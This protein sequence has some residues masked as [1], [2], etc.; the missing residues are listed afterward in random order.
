MAGAIIQIDQDRPG[1][2]VSTGSPGVARKDLWVGQVVRPTSTL[3]GNA[4]QSWS[5]V[6]KPTGSTATLN[7]ADQVTCYFTPDLPGSYR[8]RL[9]TN[10]GGAGNEQILICACTFDVTGVLIN[11]G[12][13]IPAFG[14]KASED[15]FGGTNARG[16]ATDIEKLLK[17]IFEI[18]KLVNQ[19]PPVSAAANTNQ[20]LT[21]LPTIDGYTLIA[22]DR[23]L[24][25]NQT[26]PLENGIYVAAAGAWS[27]AT[28]MAAGSR[29]GGALLV[30]LQ[31][32]VYQNSIWLCTNNPPADV[33]DTDTL[34]FEQKTL[35]LPAGDLRG[36]LANPLVKSVT[37]DAGGTATGTYTKVDETA[38]GTYLRQYRRPG[39]GVTV[40][41]GSNNDVVLWT[42]ADGEAV[43]LEGEISFQ[44]NVGG[45]V[46]LTG[47]VKLTGQAY[48]SGGG[49]VIK[50]TPTIV[51]VNDTNLTVSLQVSGNDVVL[52]YN[53]DAVNILYVG[54]EVFVQRIKPV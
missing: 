12:W 9:V 50:G 6:D 37:G 34:L 27:R 20:A 7:D 40:G 21:G 47:L 44:D 15:N 31:G 29:Q 25:T 26:T 24:L 5:L 23:V 52:R 30:V 4:S 54:W 13:R 16:W 53:D 32:T 3:A 17:D 10:T 19:H 2:S 48:R 14:E 38:L 46:T 22:G 1:P 42:L 49:A 45:V 8:L 41:D 39:S 28:D 33:V 11:S 18:V 35:S 51:Q 43:T 36:T